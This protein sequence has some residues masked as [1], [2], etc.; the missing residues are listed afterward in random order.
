MTHTLAPPPSLYQWVISLFLSS[1][2][3]IKDV[4]VTNLK[5][6]RKGGNGHDAFSL[7]ASSNHPNHTPFF[8]LFLSPLVHYMCEHSNTRLTSTGTAVAGS[9]DNKNDSK[10]R[11]G[12]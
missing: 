4:G 6:R 12:R 7:A 5:G 1:A 9:A 10:D 8:F 2:T 3:P 11:K